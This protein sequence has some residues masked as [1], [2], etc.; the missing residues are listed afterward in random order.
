MSGTKKPLQSKTIQ[1]SVVQLIAAVFI[2]VI[3][4]IN[5]DE[6]G[7]LLVEVLGAEGVALGLAAVMAVKS[8][9][10]VWVRF[11]TDTSIG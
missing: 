3:G 8:F 1:T 7:G 2:A 10:D 11:N 5:G 9:W 4:F 6:T